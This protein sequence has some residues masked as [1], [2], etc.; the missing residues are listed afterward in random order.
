MNKV[1]ERV[2]NRRIAGRQADNDVSDKKCKLCT[3][4][5]FYSFFPVPPSIHA[6][7]EKLVCSHQKRMAASSAVL[8]EETLRFSL[9]GD[10][11]NV[12]F[13]V[14]DT[15]VTELSFQHHG[16][17]DTFIIAEWAQ[18]GQNRL[19]DL[20]HSTVHDDGTPVHRDASLF[21]AL[22]AEGHPE[23]LLSVDQRCNVIRQAVT[24][25]FTCLDQ[26]MTA[27]PRSVL[28]YAVWYREN[29]ARDDTYQEY[30]SRT[31]CRC[32]VRSEFLSPG[33]VWDLT[34]F[35]MP[36]QAAVTTSPQ[37]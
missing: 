12:S 21:G 37:G 29:H 14:R 36:A 7:Y 4:W 11:V 28:G 19:L 35:V 25:V 34:E 27:Q 16:T 22:D 8:R 23:A 33:V 13:V 2:L 9:L 17:H 15:F 26:I 20:F 31:T 6:N 30:I 18:R 1:G 3:S 10:P 24:D 5:Y 32:I